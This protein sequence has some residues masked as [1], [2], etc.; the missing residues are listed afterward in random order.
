MAFLVWMVFFDQNRLTNQIDL[1]REIREL[2]QN[3]EY[4]REQIKVVQE[5]R[6]DLNNNLERF[7]R[8]KYYF[9]K[10]DEDVFIIE[11]N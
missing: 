8:E 1:S 5:A 7:A 6:T 11:K 4:Y 10:S 2:E 9:K 3:K